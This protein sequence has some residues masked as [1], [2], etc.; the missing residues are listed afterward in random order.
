MYKATVIQVDMSRLKRFGSWLSVDL[1]RHYKKHVCL[2]E[3]GPHARDMRT[4]L[5]SIAN[6]I[7]R[8]CTT[9]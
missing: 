8:T 5:S 2:H 3:I 4:I 7:E 6:V 1:K 9:T